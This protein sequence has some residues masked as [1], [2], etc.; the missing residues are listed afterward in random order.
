VQSSVYVILVANSSD[1]ENW[2]LST[3]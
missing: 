2:N 1:W 3:S